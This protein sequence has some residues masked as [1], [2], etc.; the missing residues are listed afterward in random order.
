MPV[1]LYMCSQLHPD[2]LLHGLLFNNNI[3]HLSRK[4]LLRCLHARTDLCRENISAAI[5]I[6]R[7]GSTSGLKDRCLEVLDA[8]ATEHR[9]Y[10][11]I[12]AAPY[13]ALH[14]WDGTIETIAADCCGECIARLK[15]IA[16]K[17]RQAL[18]KRLAKSWMCGWS[19]VPGDSDYGRDDT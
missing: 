17:E 4:D 19:N 10:A 3:E 1:A 2:V 13:D 14:D 8:I 12:G 11:V 15:E 5:K 9:I 16:A 18:W 6:W 7:P